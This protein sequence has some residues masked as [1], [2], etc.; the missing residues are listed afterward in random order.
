MV[1]PHPTPGLQ[2]LTRGQGDCSC[3]DLSVAASV[4]ASDPYTRGAVLHLVQ[5]IE[6]HIL[7]RRANFRLVEELQPFTVEKPRHLPQRGQFLEACLAS[8]SVITRCAWRGGAGRGWE[9]GGVRRIG[10]R[11]SLRQ[12]LDKG[13]RL[14]KSPPHPAPRSARLR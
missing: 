7:R 12:S 10:Q 14:T 4:P 2:H 13:S 1:V 11:G 8:R 9:E 5:K 6:T 3:G